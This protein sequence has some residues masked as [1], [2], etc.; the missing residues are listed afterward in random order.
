MLRRFTKKRAAVGLGVVSALVLSVAAYAYFTSTGTGS[1]SASVGS[2]T[3][4]T[5]GESGTPSSGALYPDASIGGAN[6]QTHHYTVTN[7]GSG[8]QNLSQ[9][10]ISVAKSDGSSWSAQADSSKPACTA[11][12]FSVGAQSVGSSWNDTSQAADYTAGQAK[13]GTVTVEMIDNG[14]NQDNCQGVSVPLYF[15]AS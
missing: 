5:V 3:H 1:G 10:V 9:V 6:V 11:S 2:A 13:T 8:S 15:S 12:D 14:H 4:W 7:G